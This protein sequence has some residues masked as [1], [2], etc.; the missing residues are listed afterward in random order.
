MRILAWDE[1][2]PALEAERLA[3]SL[4]AFSGVL[5]RRTVEAWRR[6]SGGPTEYVGVFAVERGHLV[7]Q[8]LALRIPYRTVSGAIAAVGVASV[9]TRATAAHR[10][11]ARTLLEE[12]HRRERDAGTDL[13]L[14]W[15]SPSWFA[16][17]LY[18][19]LGYHDVYTPSVAVRLLG[20]DPRL[21]PRGRL[22]R[23]RP[24]DLAG[25]EALHGRVTAGSL[26]FVPR[27][28]GFLR[29]SPWRRQRLSGLRVYEREGRLRGYAFVSA[30]RGLL[31]CGE[32]V[33]GPRDR[34]GL[35]D[36]LEPTASPGA[37]ELGN[38]VV[39]LLRP[40]L[41]RRGY[42]VGERQDWRTLMACSLRG[43]LSAAALRRRLGVDRPSFACMSL[44]RF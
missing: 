19:G 9:T 41:A 3:L 15:T 6:A 23:A 42:F 14:L 35:L 1:L 34:A 29:R 10:G 16:H 8:V 17:R 11:V 26:G 36:A 4:A 43:A 30:E 2:S 27:P 39:D 12:V 5:D 31:R 32:L 28:R 33:A 25:L 20:R 38:R 37:L 40:E 44:D 21:R 7:G 13:A 24:G 18:E 22:R